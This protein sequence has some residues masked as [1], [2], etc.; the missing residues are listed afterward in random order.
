MN[1]LKWVDISKSVGI[2]LVVYGHLVERVYNA[3]STVAFEQF[4]FI[5]AFHMPLFFFSAGFFCKKPT[6]LL[7]DVRK[8]FLRRVIPVFTFALFFIPVWAFWLYNINEL[9]YTF[10]FMGFN[11]ILGKPSFDIITW[12]LICL[13]TCE[14]YA[15]FILTKFQSQRSL[16]LIVVIT[17]T[18]GVY[19]CNR[20][21]PTPGWLG[22]STNIWYIQEAIVALGFYLAGY[23]AFPY[24][25]NTFQKR[26][27]L[28]SSIITCIAGTILYY[29]YNLNAPA[30]DFTVMMIDS[31]HGSIIPFLVSAFAGIILIIFVSSLIPASKSFLFIGQNTLI[32]LGLNGIFHLFLN[33]EIVEFFTPA[34][35]WISV[36]VYCIIVTDLSILVC[37]P[38]IYLFNKYIPQLMGKPNISGPLLPSLED[39]S[40]A[41]V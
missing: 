15:L 21:P 28:I 22:L 14:V 24:L 31:V 10:F 25:K 40:T 6:T 39:K 13:F 20:F 9:N 36:T 3:G 4:K 16:L 11:Y 12:F 8:L 1:R 35:N 26:N 37:V 2:F 23:L 5:Y 7:A 17:L 18:A 19:L 27:F 29:T 30:K 32:L 41:T 33:R 38:F 34:D